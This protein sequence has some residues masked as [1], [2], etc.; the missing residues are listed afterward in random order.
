MGHRTK[1]GSTPNAFHG[2]RR[3]WCRSNRKSMAKKAVY[4]ELRP[5]APYFFSLLKT[6]SQKMD[7]KPS[8][9]DCAKMPLL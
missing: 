3:V 6:L 2:I 7:L 5:R 8:T 1:T 9:A 4:R